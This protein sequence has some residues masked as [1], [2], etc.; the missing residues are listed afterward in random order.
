MVNALGSTS[1]STVTGTSSGIAEDFEQFLSILLTQ[2][3][4]QNPLE[5]LDTNEFTQQLVQF[6]EIEQSLQTNDYLEEIVGNTSSSEYV[7]AVNYIGTEVVADGYITQLSGGDATWVVDAEDDVT[8]VFYSVYDEN[9]SVIYQ[10]S[11]DFNKGM[12]LLEWNGRDTTG[13]SVPDGPYGIVFTA[14]DAN[15]DPVTLDTQIAGKVTGV[16]FS[17]SLIHI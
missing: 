8:D 7:N 15:G 9:G 14:T 16:D 4:N 13:Q 6:S 17:L 10:D 1:S 2:L 5:P 12:N 11:V 3:Q